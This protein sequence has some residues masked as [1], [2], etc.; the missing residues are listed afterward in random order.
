MLSLIIVPVFYLSTYIILGLL[1]CHEDGGRTLLR[2]IFTRQQY[3]AF[4]KTNLYS[5]RFE[6]VYLHKIIKVQL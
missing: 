3:V 4:Q 1:F 5:Y 2:N 6:D